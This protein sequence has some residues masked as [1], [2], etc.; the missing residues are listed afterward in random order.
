MSARLIVGTA[1]AFTATLCV[2]SAVAHITGLR[3]NLS[4]SAPAG[5]WRV[6][7]VDSTI[8]RGDLVEVCAPILPVTLAMR[9]RGALPPGDC[10]A[11]LAPLLK[12]V[13]AV[14]G[15]QVR[16]KA[17]KLVSVNGLSL[18]GSAAAANMPNWPDGLYILPRG[19]VWLTS[20]YSVSSFDSRYF[21][22]V[23]LT[24]IRGR[25]VP[26]IVAG[27]VSHMLAW[28]DDHD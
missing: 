19:A 6:V 10:P 11:D 3:L 15:D 26:L 14:A 22:P 7:V 25:A 28:E 9:Q 2:V 20:S 12:P 17:G 5:L 1:W 18:A 21:G 27:D 8:S 23:P 24:H 4:A 13:A 16:V